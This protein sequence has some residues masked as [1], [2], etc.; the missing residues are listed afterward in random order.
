MVLLL[1]F[2]LNAS[3]AE[4]PIDRRYTLPDHGVFQMK[5]PPSWKEEIAQPPNALPPTIIFS[6]AKGNE[7]KIIITPI[8]KE[9]DDTPVIN[10]AAA[11]RMVERAMSKAQPNAAEKNLKMVEMKGSAGN[12]YY[13]SATDK[14]P[15]PGGYKF[16]T[17]G[18]LLVDELVVTFTILTND[19]QGV[20]AGAA[21]T[22]LKTAIYVKEK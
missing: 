1:I 11:Q 13:F 10:D 15:E 6:P 2:S 4:Q 8:W 5:V 16:L 20:V 17:Q 21:I 19:D 14:A 22:M 7:F 18:I 12:G 3:A 9:R